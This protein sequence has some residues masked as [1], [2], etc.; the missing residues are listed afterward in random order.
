MEPS[1]PRL[2]DPINH[3]AAPPPMLA[4]RRPFLLKAHPE[5]WHVMAG[6]FV[7]QLGRFTLRGGVG[8]VQ[9]MRDGAF[10]VRAAVFDQEARLG[11]QVIPA[12][13]DGPG[14]SYLYE[15][16]VGCFL[17]RF[18]RAFPGSNSVRTDE[19]AYSAWCAS[20]VTRGI[21]PKPRIDIIERHLH[22]A[23]GELLEAIDQARDS[24]PSA[25]NHREA[26]AARVALLERELAAAL[27]DVEGQ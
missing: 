24:L 27:S 12:D 18:E 8:Q 4:D 3:N 10:D 13:V 20:L 25:V 1:A 21:I 2:R 26:V 5:R 6:R 23:Q 14:T 19:D 11:W 22:V 17:S 15:P 16:V 9:I 7:P